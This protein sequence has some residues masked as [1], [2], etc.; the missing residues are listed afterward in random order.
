MRLRLLPTALAALALSCA[1]PASTSGPGSST[2]PSSFPPTATTSPSIAPTPAPSPTEA[3]TP[4]PGPVSLTDLAPNIPDAFV[5]LQANIA[6]D[7]GASRTPTFTAYRD[8]HVL[9]WSDGPRVARLT[10]GGLDSLQA[11]VLDAGF[12]SMASSVPIDP[13]YNGGFASYYIALRRGDAL[14]KRTTTNVPDPEHRGEADAIIALVERIADIGHVLPG[15]AWA[16]P[17][18]RAVA[19][20]PAK[21][22]FKVTTY[23]NP[24][25]PADPS[26]PKL[27]VAEVRWPF[28]T[29][30]VQFGAPLAGSP[31]GPGSRSRCAV[32]TLADAARIEQAIAPAPWSD[33]RIPTWERMAATLTWNAGHGHV[34]ISLGELLP[35][36]PD[37]CA[38]DLSLP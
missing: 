18:A 29:S 15:S 3:S 4:S 9:F 5:I 27:D 21:L 25:D 1:A 38:V 12:L 26:R 14:V 2:G 36:E 19:Y 22:L 10:T 23:D 16:V 8:G 11:L 33:E 28:A 13:S 24:L 20:V 35:G 37:D 17:P 7:V 6:G 32:V 34:D 30:L 31:L